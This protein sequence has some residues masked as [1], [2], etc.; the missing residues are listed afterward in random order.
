MWSA[1][2]EAPLVNRETETDALLGALKDVEGGRGRAVL[3]LGEAGIGKSRLLAE[4]ARAAASRRC[5]IVAGRAYS[6]TQILPFGAWLPV[7]QTDGLAADRALLEALPPGVRADLARLLP[8]FEEP[9]QPRP[10]G[11]AEATR[12]F[13]AV[14]QLLATWSR[15]Q[16]LVVVLEDLHWADEMSLRLLA[17][18]AR[19]WSATRL[20]L[21]GSARDDEIGDSPLLRHVIDELL[22]ER[23]LTVVNVGPLS[24]AATGA[25]VRTLVSAGPAS[26]GAGGLGRASGR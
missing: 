5:A 10:S 24:E 9:G 1:L 16:P 26:T 25:L 18:I 6:S 11:P 7:L 4:F 15:R 3:M 17:F 23:R 13:E 21:V 14:A 8:E 22:A 12:L 19:R 20:L 2:T